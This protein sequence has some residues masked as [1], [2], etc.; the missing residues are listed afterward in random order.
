MSCAGHHEQSAGSRGEEVFALEQVY[1]Q[2]SKVV[3]LSE[4]EEYKRK[5]RL[6]PNRCARKGEAS[7][8]A[9]VFQTGVW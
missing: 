5:Y 2:E 7:G 1:L 6:R 9:P 3:C 4:L 8:G